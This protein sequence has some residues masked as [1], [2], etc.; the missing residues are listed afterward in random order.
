MRYTVCVKKRKKKWTSERERERE[1]ESQGNRCCRHVLMMWY[2]Y[3]PLTEV[4]KNCLW[5]IVRFAYL[6]LLLDFVLSI[7]ITN[8]FHLCSPHLWL[9]PKY[10]PL[11][12]TVHETLGKLEWQTILSEFDSHW[13]PNTSGLVPQLSSQ[14]KKTNKNSG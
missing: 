3:Y 1:R 6:G 12:E 8:P 2:V 13:V 5:T 11:H 7:Q 4:R 14:C 9:M 10:F